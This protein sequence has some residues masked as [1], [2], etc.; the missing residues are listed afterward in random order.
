MR[1]QRQFAQHQP[2][3][4]TN[5]QHGMQRQ[6][7]AVPTRTTPKSSRRQ[8]KRCQTAAALDVREVINNLKQQAQKQKTAAVLGILGAVAAGLAVAGPGLAAD[9]VK[10]GTC[11]LGNCQ[12][13]LATCIADPECLE[14][15]ACLQLCNGRQDEAGCQI[16]CGDLYNDKAVQTF[17]ACAVS[18]KKCV[19]QKIDRDAFPE[20]KPEALDKNFD[21]GKFEGRWYITAGLNPLF[22]DFDCQEHYFG[23]PEPGKLYGKINWRI[24]KPDN[25]FIDR[26][27]VQTFKQQANPAMLYN[28]GNDYLHYEDTWYILASKPDEYVV[29]YYIGNNDAWK[30]YGG[31]TV[32]T[33]APSLPDQYVPEIKEALAKI[34]QKWEDWKVTDNSCKPHP[35][36]TNLLQSAERFAEYEFGG[37]EKVLETDLKSFGKGFSVFEQNVV[38]TITGEEKIVS[39]EIQEAEKYL[40]G[41]EKQYGSQLPQWLNWGPFK[42]LFGGGSGNYGAA[43]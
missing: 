3:S 21:L 9:M 35:P 10:T 14:N 8:T 26:S 22:D 42:T 28:G 20:P 11:L 2:F 29:V 25:D 27:T 32:Y 19:P 1:C 13:Q 37:L 39:D 30:G 7:A 4:S 6:N 34:G 43:R 17:T 40:E 41:I 18:D 5:F 33:R 23:V 12:L 38:N 36:A 31:G 15:L 16:R 24:K